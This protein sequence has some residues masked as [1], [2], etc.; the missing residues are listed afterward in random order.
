ME[1]LQILTSEDYTI[2][3]ERRK[4]VF[5]S[6]L[7]YKNLDMKQINKYMPVPVE[8]D[9]SLLKRLT[10]PETTSIARNTN[11]VE[12]IFVWQEGP[13]APFFIESFPN[14]FL[15]TD[16]WHTYNEGKG[17]RHFLDSFLIRRLR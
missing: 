5:T 10:L 2:I 17:S 16:L 1:L 3:P 9:S 11:L 6:I 15:L 12:Q 4:T 13:V 14:H 7:M 8:P